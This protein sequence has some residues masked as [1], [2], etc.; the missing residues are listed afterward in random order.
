MTLIIWDL[1]LA[2]S[3]EN[4]C[5]RHVTASLVCQSPLMGYKLT[6]AQCCCLYGEAWGLQCALC[7]RRDEGTHTHTRNLLLFSFDSHNIQYCVFNY[8]SEAYEAL[9]N[10][11][12]PPPYS[13]LYYDRYGLEVPPGR[14]GYLP[15]YGPPEFP[16]PLPG[17]PEYH[18]TDYDDYSS[19]GA[20]G[21][22]SGLRERP[23]TSYGLPDSPYIRPSTGYAAWL[24]HFQ[25]VWHQC[26]FSEI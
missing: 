8:S 23:P 26:M 10:E 6:F 24:I 9:C 3:D 25:S 14:G 1:C 22:R 2:C 13:P 21:R 7:P 5:W 11:L 4:F 18:P 12:G 17:R 19:V 16:E 15:P 20:G